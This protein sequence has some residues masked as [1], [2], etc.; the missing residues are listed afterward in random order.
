MVHPADRPVCRACTGGSQLGTRT[1]VPRTARHPGFAAKQVPRGL[2]WRAGRPLGSRIDRLEGHLRRRLM[3]FGSDGRTAEHS[4]RGR[5]PPGTSHSSLWQRSL[6]G[7]SSLVAE[8]SL[9][10]EDWRPKGSRFRAHSAIDTPA[11][12]A[13]RYPHRGRG[14]QTGRE[15]QAAKRRPPSSAPLLMNSVR[16]EPPG[17]RRSPHSG[18]VRVCARAHDA[19]PTPSR[20]SF[21]SLWLRELV[22]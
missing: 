10:S 3:I 22:A 21:I 8:V 17:S 11:A 6:S 4:G 12:P 1:S 13:R 18:S 5:R 16:R 7:R 9:G 19:S 2:P 14:G 15:R 20:C